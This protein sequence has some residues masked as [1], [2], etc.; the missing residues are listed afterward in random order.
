MQADLD[1]QKQ[2]NMLLKDTIDRLRQDLQ[3]LR[4]THATDTLKLSGPGGRNSVAP[5]LSRSLGSELARRL[6]EAKSDEDT[7]D[8]ET[9]VEREEVNH[10]TDGEDEDVVQTIITRKRVCSHFL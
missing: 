4:D 6:A 2:D 8:N 5:S 3:E 10:G 7:T 9:T 1:G